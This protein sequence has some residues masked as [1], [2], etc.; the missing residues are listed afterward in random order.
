MCDTL[1]DLVP[2]VVFKNHEKHPMKEGYSKSNT[3]PWFVFMFFKLYKW[4]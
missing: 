4:Y 1:R 3:P 2:F